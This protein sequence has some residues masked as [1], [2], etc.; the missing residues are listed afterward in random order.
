M[1][2][3]PSYDPASLD[4]AQDMVAQLV[5]S[6][7]KE[8]GELTKMVDPNTA[9]GRSTSLERFKQVAEKALEPV[10]NSGHRQAARGQAVPIPL[11]TVS[12]PKGPAVFTPQP[13]QQQENKNQLEF[14][15]DDSASAKNIKATVER[16]E[17]AVLRLEKQVKKLIELSEK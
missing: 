7:Y 2:Y 13:V 14:D 9:L 3:D 5:G 11:D 15:F 1:E 10:V 4:G 16:I 12:R 6:T 17:L 8:F